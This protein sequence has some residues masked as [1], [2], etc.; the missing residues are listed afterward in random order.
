[1][2]AKAENAVIFIDEAYNLDPKSD[3]KGKAIANEILTLSEN[4]RDEISIILAG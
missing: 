1:M 3:S 4:K 2:V